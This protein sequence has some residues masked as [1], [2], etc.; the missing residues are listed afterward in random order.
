MEKQI[1]LQLQLQLKQMNPNFIY[2][3]TFA[4]SGNVF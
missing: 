2:R 1:Q 3:V 4:D